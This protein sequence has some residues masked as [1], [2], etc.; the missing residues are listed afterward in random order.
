MSK[1][2]QITVEVNSEEKAKIIEAIL[3][4]VEYTPS[5]PSLGKSKK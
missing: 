5:K 2:R 1:K 4:S 3:N